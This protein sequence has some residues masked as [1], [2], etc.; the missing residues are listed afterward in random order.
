MEHTSPAR[1]VRP[2]AE[3]TGLSNETVELALDMVDA[4]TRSADTSGLPSAVAAGCLYA[5]ALAVDTETAAD[6]S[7]GRKPKPNANWNPQVTHNR[8]DHGSTE[9]TIC[10]AASITPV[11]LRKHSRE[12]IAIYLDSDAEM[13]DAHTRKQLA[14]LRLR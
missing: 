11:S 5:A 9:T 8:A 2:L 4:V 7:S 3:S 6:R 1:S 13:A 12:A 14:R 10:K